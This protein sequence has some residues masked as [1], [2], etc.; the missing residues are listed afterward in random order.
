VGPTCTI[1][2]YLLKSGFGS[3]FLSQMNSVG[4]TCFDHQS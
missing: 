4:D 1:V 2:G 3:S